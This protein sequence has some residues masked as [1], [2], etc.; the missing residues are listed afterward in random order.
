MDGLGSGD[1]NFVFN[2]YRYKDSN[3]WGRILFDI[4]NFSKKSL[5]SIKNIN[6]FKEKFYN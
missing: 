5:E 1:W 3:T 4:A 2:K 6:S